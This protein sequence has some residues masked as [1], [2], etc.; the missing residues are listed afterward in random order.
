M[1]FSPRI[2]AFLEHEMREIKDV[3]DR[4]QEDRKHASTVLGR[5]EGETETNKRRNAESEGSQELF[6]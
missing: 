4:R 2:L 6:S 5:T 3:K 1:G